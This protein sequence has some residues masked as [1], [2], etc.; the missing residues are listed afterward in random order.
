MGAA[1]SEAT[2][3]GLRVL[4]VDDNATNRLV[5]VKILEALG[6][7]GVAC[8]GGAEAVEAVQAEAYDLVLMDVS[9][10]GMDGMEATRIIR[11]LPGRTAA[12]PIV[13]LTA[14][15]MTHQRQAYLSAGMD[16][17]VA[18]PFS[19]ADLLAEVV[20]VLSVAEDCPQTANG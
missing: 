16:G 5:G 7:E 10:P 6:A 12:T 18:K 15:V 8:E 1:P 14:N 11:A 4:L 2:L 3:C 17:V 13:A 19:P 20:R 9:M